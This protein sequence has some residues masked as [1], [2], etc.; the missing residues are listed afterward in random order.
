[1]SQPHDESQQVSPT[2]FVVSDGRGD[3]CNQLVRSALVQY[4]QQPCEL[5]RW[6]EIRTPEQV[7][8]VIEA[9]SD[10]HATIFY[11]LVSPETRRVMRDRSEQQMVPSVDVLGPAFSALHDLFKRD[12]AATPGLFYAS[13]REQFDRHAAIDYTLKHDDGRRP[14]GLDK[15]DVI[16]VGVS[17]SSK[18]STC[19]YLAYRGIK[20]ANVPLLPNVPIPAQLKE[21]SAE[22][23]IGLR[24]NVSRLMTI[25][26][27]RAANLGH[28]H[29]DY[30]LDKREIGRE[31]LHAH[32]LMAVNQWR[33]FDA[34]YMAVEE[35]AREVIR[36]RKLD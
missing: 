16:L 20:A 27:A 9:A 35:I 26:E 22:K 30:Y 15:A 13:E 29:T 10:R 25:R 36:L 28:R 19:F 34:S 31:V 32:Q 33:S 1:V 17:R 3:T 12:P 5:V 23:I 18:S 14:Y 6:A 21:V 8:E 11:T 4:A 2:I 24:V 7:N